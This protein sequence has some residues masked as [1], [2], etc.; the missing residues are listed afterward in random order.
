MI[1]LQNFS[2]GY[3]GRT[4]LRDATVVFGNS[5]LTALI[6]RN[7]SGKSTLLRAIAGLNRHYSGNI[8]L[9]GHDLSLMKPQQ[10][11]HTIAFVNTERTRIASLRCQDVVAMGRA[12]Y[13]NWFGRM[14]DIDREAVAQALACTGMTEYALRTMDTMSD[15]ECQR[16]MIARALAQDTP[17]IIL[18]EPT[19]FLDLPSRYELVALLRELAHN[20]G[21]CVLF[22]T[23]ELDIAMQQ[24]DSIA[25][26]DT[27]QLRHLPADEM[28]HSE[29]IDR[30][31]R[32]DTIRFDAESGTMKLS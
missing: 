31:F 2:T 6:G 18:D 19:S 30:L 13:T 7:G 29:Y 26:L 23:H 32:N 15:G 20:S 27:P 25:L 21:R 9:D 4:L 17:T 3:S 5:S 16:I 11:A 10:L 14:Q 22:S 8:L 12:P 24:C 1:E 28:R